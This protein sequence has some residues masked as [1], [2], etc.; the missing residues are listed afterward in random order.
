MILIVKRLLFYTRV[1]QPSGNMD[2]SGFFSVQVLSKALQVWN[3]DLILYN[4]QEPD[5]L[6]AQSAPQ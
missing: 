2:D 4:S 1:Q 3:L 6:Q 5:A